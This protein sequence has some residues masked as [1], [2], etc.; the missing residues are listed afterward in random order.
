M[1][2]TKDMPIMKSAFPKG[3]SV[4]AYCSLSNWL[5]S[6][7]KQ[8]WKG[9]TLIFGVFAIQAVKPSGVKQIYIL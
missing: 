2:M 6:Q 3:S 1:K 7:E 4:Q 9:R 5:M 8:E